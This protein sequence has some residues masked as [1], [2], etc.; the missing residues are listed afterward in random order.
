MIA[1]RN[2]YWLGGVFL[3]ASLLAGFGP[4]AETAARKFAAADSSKQRVAIVDESGAILWEHRIGPL[5][6]LHVLPG[7]NLLLQLSWTRIVEID[8]ATDKIVWEYDSAKQNGNAGKRIEVHAFQRLANGDTMIAESGATRIIEVDRRGAMTHEVKLR[9]SNPHPHLDTRLVRKLANGNYLVCHEGEGLVRE[10]DPAGAT[11]WE[12]KVPLF[13]RQPKPGH[14]VEAFGNKC[15]SAVRLVS[16]NTLIG[17][18]NGHSVIEVTP[19][20]EIVWEL[21]QND[22]PGIQLAWV[23]TLQ[24]LSSGNIVIGNCHA[25][26]ENPQLVEVTRD[27]KVVWQFRDFEHFGNALTNSQMLAVDGQPVR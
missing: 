16:G 21:H 13:G 15:F 3:A 9:V 5:H 4:A 11:A 18:G 2:R 7:G 27:K 24:V 10:Y 14:G 23:T 20:K 22:L 6:D 1:T 26:P 25:G 17:T 19:E 12:F 8:P